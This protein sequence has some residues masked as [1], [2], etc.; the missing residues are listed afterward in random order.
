MIK[1]PLPIPIQVR[2]TNTVGDILGRAKVITSLV[3]ELENLKKVWIEKID[4]AEK[5]LDSRNE[6]YSEEL[7]TL[8]QELYNF[9]KSAEEEINQRIK[10]VY[11][12][13]K[14]EKGAD[15]IDGKNGKDGISPQIDTQEIAR[16]VLAKL[17]F[18]NTDK[19]EMD[20]DETKLL[21]KLDKKLNIKHIDGLEQTL[22][23]L[24][25]QTKQGYL[26]GGGV[27]SLQAGQ[28]IV[29]TKTSDGG[30]SI[31]ST[32]SGGGFTELPAKGNID[33][34]N[35]TFIF[36]QKPNRIISDHV[37]YKE[38]LGWSWDNG[39]LT[40]TMTVPPVDELYGYV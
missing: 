23:A 35:V 24:Q 30:Y 21:E 27:P 26:H 25:T 34:M 40:A 28:G 16:S 32:A 38:N 39:T 12:G 15:G 2:S 17:P 33:G 29:L 11:K 9:L 14:G 3:Q 20:I 6:V 4:T 36:T 37:W 22:H 10:T 1:R 31:T 5:S 13:D 18:I 19:E 7:S 8:K